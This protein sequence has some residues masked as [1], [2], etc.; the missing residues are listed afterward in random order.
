MLFGLKLCIIKKHVKFWLHLEL[1][2]ASTGVNGPGF[3][4]TRKMGHS[5]WDRASTS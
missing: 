2:S 1:G 4:D 5:L 3:G